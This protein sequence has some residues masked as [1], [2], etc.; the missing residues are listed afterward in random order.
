[1][2]QLIL[3]LGCHGQVASELEKVA[4]QEGR[5]VMLAGRDVLDLITAEEPTILLDRYR[6]AA[7]I[8]AAAFSAVDDAE[9]QPEPAFRLNGEVPTLYARACAERGLPFVHFSSDYVFDGRKGAPYL[10]DDVRAPLNVYGRTKLQSEEGVAAEGDLWTVLRTS[11]LFSSF[12]WNFV[13]TMLRLAETRDEISVVHDQIGRPTWAEDCARVSLMAVDA[14][15]EGRRE[16]VGLF[17]LSGEGDASWADLAEAALTVSAETGGPTATVRRV[18]SDQYVTAAARPHD[19]RL[20]AGKLERALGWRAR[21][22]REGLARSM[23][24]MA[25]APAPA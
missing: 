20:D 7:V 5:R 16:A 9:R 6:P 10:E 22:W 19:S 12:G 13:K 15:L 3:V 25:A 8:N 4:A 11:W 1:M 18:T 23:A 17:H 14:L 2:S 21:P 24:D